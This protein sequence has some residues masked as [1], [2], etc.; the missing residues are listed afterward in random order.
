[1]SVYQEQWDP[2]FRALLQDYD[3]IRLKNLSNTIYGIW[4]DFTYAYLNRGW[5]E[6]AHAN[7]GDPEICEEWGLG[8][9]L[10]DAISDDLQPYYRRH[11]QESLVENRVW[12]HEYEC[13]SNC[14]YRIFRQSA[15]PLSGQGLLLVNALIIEEPHSRI[16]L[17]PDAEEQLGYYDNHGYAH[18]C[19]HCRKTQSMTDRKR[20]DWIPDWVEHPPR[21]TSHGLCP[22]CF[23]YYY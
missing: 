1:M 4:A 12:E 9:N 11:Y 18:Q 20:W 19:C 5:F 23:N 13:S 15:Y 16:A 8:R 3:F 21:N 2:K 17:Y 7:G 6:F 22:V 10:L 14:L